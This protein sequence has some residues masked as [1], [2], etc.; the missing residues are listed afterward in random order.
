[1]LDSSNN[2]RNGLP[3][4]TPALN[5]KH[6]W[7]YLF[8]ITALI[9]ALVLFL[10][11]S[12]PKPVPAG[13]L[14]FFTNDNIYFES[15]NNKDYIITTGSRGKFYLAENGMESEITG[16]P[17][18]IINY[19]IFPS[20]DLSY[21]F[22]SHTAGVSSWDCC[23]VFRI[24][25]NSALKLQQ[26]EYPPHVSYNK[27]I[28]GLDNGVLAIRDKERVA[29]INGQVET[30]IEGLPRFTSVEQGVQD[31]YGNWYIDLYDGTEQKSKQYFLYIQ[32]ATATR[33]S[34]NLSHALFINYKGKIYTSL[35]KNGEMILAMCD[36]GVCTE[37]SGNIIPKTNTGFSWIHENDNLYAYTFNGI[38][39]V[40]DS[41]IR[42]ITQTS[43]LTEIA[44][45]R[46]FLPIEE[47]DGLV[48]YEIIGSE[49][50]RL[51]NLPHKYARFIGSPVTGEIYIKGLVDTD[52]F[53][54]NSLYRLE[55]KTF[56]EI[57][58]NGSHF[59]P[60]E[61]F[62]DNRGNVFVTRIKDGSHDLFLIKNDIA[63]PILHEGI[64]ISYPT[65]F[66]NN[67]STY[68]K[69]GSS[70]YKISLF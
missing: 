61:I 60:S 34:E 41:N 14:S 5:K 19:S 12:G 51:D 49:L 7:K 20:N 23:D 50:V 37:L 6:V 22:I 58:V 36:K 44:N 24:V 28:K 13:N 30:R 70:Y 46:V 52:I 8:I 42:R 67:A 39:L 26:S 55:D 62:L 54:G 27:F 9:F 47:S 53:G 45:S 57:K 1:M 29:V 65:F 17:S 68:V 16:L 48:V 64:D 2:L 32:N 35:F 11:K 3:A 56:K 63:H 40:S 18:T 10:N 31:K 15:V 4:Y 38:Y 66:S 43:A 69:T 21:L 33:I 59:K 25:G